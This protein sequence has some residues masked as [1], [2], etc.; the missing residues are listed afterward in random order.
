MKTR[1]FIFALCITAILSSCNDETETKTVNS[2]PDSYFPLALNNIWAY[3]EAGVDNTVTEKFNIM[4]TGQETKN[5]QTYYTIENARYYT[6]RYLRKTANG[7]IMELLRDSV[8]TM[9]IPA[10][11]V[12]DSTWYS[13]DSLEY[14]TIS[15]LNAVVNAYDEL[16][17]IVTYD[18]ETG[19]RIETNKY[20][21]GVG[22]IQA[23][24]KVNNQILT[25]YS[26]ELK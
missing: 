21:M 20:R 9:I 10:T 12:I 1:F 25:I 22:Y 4:V 8:E 11:V 7:E 3:K 15:S 16:L 26:Y 13:P 24:D 14:R 5:G 2:D 18:A 6:T 23:T 19:D 17:E